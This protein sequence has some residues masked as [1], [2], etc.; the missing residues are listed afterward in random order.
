MDRTTTALTRGSGT[1]LG[2]TSIGKFAGQHVAARTAREFSNQLSP[3]RDN[4]LVDQ[5]E[6]EDQN[7]L[8]RGEDRE[9]DK[10]NI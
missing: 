5:V 6:N 7:S 8:H 4:F 9:Q 1:G 2:G 3:S 10:E